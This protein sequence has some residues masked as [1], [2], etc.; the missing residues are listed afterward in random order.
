MKGFNS[1]FWRTVPRTLLTRSGDAYE[2]ANKHPKEAALT[3]ISVYALYDMLKD[4][5]SI[6]AVDLYLLL[7]INI[8]T[9]AAMEWQV[10]DSMKSI[11]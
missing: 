10:P 6:S 3:A 4:V 7:S 11:L 1:G 9:I 2:F 8:P 5:S